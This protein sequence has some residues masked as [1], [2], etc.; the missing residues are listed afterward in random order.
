V[1]QASRALAYAFENGALSPARAFFLRAEPLP[2]KDV[3]AE[4]SF[5][6]AYLRLKQTAWSVAPRI[7]SGAYELGL[8]L[9]TKHKEENLTD[10][11][12]EVVVV[13]LKS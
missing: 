3:D 9:L 8:V 7:E 11:L 12:F 5:R 10:K 4:Q 2:F 13:E 6:P 1:T